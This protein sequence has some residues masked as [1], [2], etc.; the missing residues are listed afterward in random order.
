VQFDFQGSGYSHAF[1]LMRDRTSFAKRMKHS[2]GM[3]FFIKY[4][5]I[6]SGL[7]CLILFLQWPLALRAQ[8]SVPRPRMSI[9]ILEGEAAIHN[10]RQRKPV[11]VVVVVRDANHHPVRGAAVTFTLPEKGPGAAFRSGARTEHAETDKD[12]Y[13]IARG[14]RANNIPGQFRVAVN[15]GYAGETAT[16]TVTHFN[17]SVTESGGGSGKIAAVL[18]AIAAAAGGG[19]AFAVRKQERT[20]PSAPAAAPTP[21]GLV[22]GAGSVGPPR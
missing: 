4:T 12:G 6:P 19:A 20:A 14:L 8:L 13:A 10:V 5:Q 16:A 7:C 17:M 22:P 9:T 11:N 2:T 1:P 21:I 3:S 18:V 15:A